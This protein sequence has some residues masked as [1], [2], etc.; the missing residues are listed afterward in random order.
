MNAYS[1]SVENSQQLTQEILECQKRFQP[2]IGIVFCTIGQ[3]ARHLQDLFQQNKIELFACTTAGEIQDDQIFRNQLVC[4]FLDLDRNHFKLH[5]AP[6]NP[7]SSIN[8][9]AQTQFLV[10]SYIRSS[11]VLPYMYLRDL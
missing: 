7:I 5:L 8:I 3:D 4:L 6:R 2:T 9:S 10:A 1:C 11:L